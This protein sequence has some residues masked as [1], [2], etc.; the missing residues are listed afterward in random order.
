MN[1]DSEVD[2]NT[3][4]DDESDANDVMDG[5]GSLDPN[6]V[7]RRDAGTDVLKFGDFQI[8]DYE[9]QIENSSTVTSKLA[10]RSRTLM[11]ERTS[12]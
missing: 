9:E 10:T 11:T 12:Q 7:E 2:S 5:D 6:G 8:I 1:D 3:G 4:A